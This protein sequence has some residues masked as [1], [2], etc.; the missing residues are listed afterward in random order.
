MVRCETFPAYCEYPWTKKG[1][2]IALFSP[3]NRCLQ[4]A[5]ILQLNRQL[6]VWIK[7]EPLLVSESNMDALATILAIESHTPLQLHF[8][9]SAA[10]D[11]AGDEVGS[12]PVI[13][14]AQAVEAIIS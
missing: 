5:R 10:I 11:M 2:D 3:K 7:I 1:S 12:L 4:Y 6:I 8:E 13:R 9:D 14:Q